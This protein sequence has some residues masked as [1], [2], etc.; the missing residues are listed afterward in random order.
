MKQHKM[1]F[2]FVIEFINVTT[3]M[4]FHKIIII[5]II[6]FITTDVVVLF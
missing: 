6:K 5:I 3:Y 2:I 4:V 1:A